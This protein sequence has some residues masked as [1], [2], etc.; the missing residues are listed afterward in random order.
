MQVI[1]IRAMGVTKK[2]FMY[3]FSGSF[4]RCIPLNKE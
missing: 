2:K 1:K 3:D 4:E